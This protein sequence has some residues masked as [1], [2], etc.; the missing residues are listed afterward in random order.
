VVL[1]PIDAEAGDG[2]EL[3][4]AREVRG[5]PTFIL[6]NAKGETIDRWIGYDKR[7][8]TTAM[9]L[10]LADLST[11]NEKQDRFHSD[12]NEQVAAALARYHYSKGDY[13][14]ALN[15]YRSAETMSGN[16]AAGHG[17]E[18]FLCT[19]NGAEGDFGFT[20]RD[21]CRAADAY[22]ASP[23]ATTAG[24]MRVA[25]MMTRLA[26]ERDDQ[27]LMK[28]YLPLAIERSRDSREDEI[29]QARADL[30]PLHALYVDGDEKKAVEYKKAAMK[31]GWKD[32]AGR[33]NA[34]AWWCFENKIDLKEA[35]TLAERGVELS[36]PGSQRAMI[37]DTVAEICNSL[38]DCKE[39]VELTRRAV[40]QDPESE[41]YPKQL[42]RFEERLARM[43]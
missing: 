6:T 13:A 32:D 24:L 1:L 37:L 19:F 39:A 33:L 29:A 42:V 15:Y 17:M 11:I 18:I 2:P 38:G 25:G 7:W 26:L 10:A 9:N 4:K 14:R 43:Q 12:P 20:A 16:G 21:V 36:E 5:Y 28:P 40:E 3:R 27:Q 41:Y 34:F 31:D 23:A 35:K 30:L 22:L 8:F